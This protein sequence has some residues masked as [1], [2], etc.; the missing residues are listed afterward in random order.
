MLTDIGVY[1]PQ[2]VHFVIALLIVGVAFRLVSL[3]PWMKFT[4][5]AA[6]TLIVCGTIAAVIAVKS[7]A[8]AHGPVE[9][10]PGARQAVQEHEEWGE[11]TRDIF[12]VVSLLEIGA[13]VLANR[14]SKLKLA[15]GIRVASALVGLAGLYAVYET[16]EHGGRLVYT[17]AGGVGTRSGDPRDVQNL[18]VAG[19]YNEAMTARQS[20]DHVRAAELID[21][22][23]ALRPDDPSTRMLRIQSRIEDR[24]DPRGALQTLDSITA[25]AGD[26]RFLRFQS[27]RLRASA[28]EKLGMKDS[29]QAIMEGLRR[30]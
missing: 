20:G 6:T 27:A 25:N 14:T 15:K 3:S 16:G 10:I 11:R 7:G 8:Q 24:N 29:A 21:Q 30:R 2:I 28:Y 17:Y 18:L 26:D 22:L 1:H 5:P 19:L 23:A 9:R 12:L 13:L 4:N